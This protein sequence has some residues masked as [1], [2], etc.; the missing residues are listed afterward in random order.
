MR[1]TIFVLVLVLVPLPALAQE[2]LPD[3]VTLGELYA[4]APGSPRMLAAADLA[5]AGTGDVTAAGTPEN[6]IFSYDAFGLLWGEPTNGGSQ[7]QLMVAQRFP[8][9]GE[10]DARVRAAQAALA[11]DRSLVDLARALLE[12]DLRRAFVALLAAQDRSALLAEAR[13]ALEEVAAIVRGRAESGAGRRWDVVRIDAELATLEAQRTS[14][15]ADEVVA[16]GAIAVL[17]GRADWLPRAAG[18]WADLP[19]PGAAASTLD[20][21]RT[22]SARLLREA[23][24]ATLEHERMLAFPRF[25]LRIGHLAST[26]PEGGYL[27][28]GISIPIPLFDQNQGAIERAE[29][30]ADAAREVEEA[31]AA[32]IDAERTTARRALSLRATALREF[33]DD[34]LTGL[35]SAA[36]MASEA[37]VGGEIAVFE[38]LDAV[39]AARTMRVERV[40]VEEAYE[41][42]VVDV[43]EA[44]LVSR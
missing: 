16:S 4:L 28:G 1:S 2:V 22:E 14:A 17:L 38:L 27:F 35:S 21:P 42:A 10:L 26:W 11:A 29:H 40:A 24:E 3:E 25:D 37:Y 39:R 41:A 6:P 33:D 9:P 32:E 30:E 8:W 36:D 15:A 13:D 31:V 43:L 19:D 18:S 34:V 20:H 5:E 44:E 7:H 12:L 23:A